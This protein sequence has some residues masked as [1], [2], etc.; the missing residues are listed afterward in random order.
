MKGPRVCQP[1]FL[2]ACNQRV[3]VTKPKTRARVCVQGLGQ[4]LFI[5]R[6]Q[7]VTYG[8][9]PLLAVESTHV[10]TVLVNEALCGNCVLC[11][12]S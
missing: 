9:T 8:Q 12:V 5:N 4:A 7:C 6:S 10:N 11:T 1:P 3:G 2:N